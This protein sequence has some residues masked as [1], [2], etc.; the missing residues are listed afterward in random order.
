MRRSTRPLVFAVTVNNNEAPGR[1]RSSALKFKTRSKWHVY[2]SQFS[3]LN[4]VSVIKIDTGKDNHNVYMPTDQTTS[5]C[6][7]S[8]NFQVQIRTIT[9][10]GRECMCG[11]K[12]DSTTE[13]LVDPL[14]L[15]PE[16]SPGPVFTAG[17]SIR[18]HPDLDR[19]VELDLDA[20]FALHRNVSPRAHIDTKHDVN[21][22]P[23][24]HWASTY[25]KSLSQR[26]SSSL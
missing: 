9:R 24:K 12:V 2:C 18:F 5:R 3:A 15:N 26:S 13:Y 21:Q 8:R 17:Q 23:T 6:I 19:P 1:S 25:T 10:K 11:I 20:F 22:S 4:L 7:L 16:L 14:R